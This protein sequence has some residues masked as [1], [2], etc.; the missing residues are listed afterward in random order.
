MRSVCA[1]ALAAPCIHLPCT[2][3]RLDA[4]LC[5]QRSASFMS[6]SSDVCE[7]ECV[8]TRVRASARQLIRAV[9]SLSSSWPCNACKAGGRSRRPPSEP[10]VRT[11]GWAL[12][13]AWVAGQMRLRA[14]TFPKDDHGLQL[15]EGHAKLTTHASRPD[16]RRWKA[17]KAVLSR[18]VGNMVP[19]SPTV[20]L[21]P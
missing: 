9:L 3:H 13:C 2:P 11:A 6:V 7:H 12:H 15:K 19:G 4:C 21:G 1:A 8:L 18:G 17:A 14:E 16:C 20:C 10:P 5:L